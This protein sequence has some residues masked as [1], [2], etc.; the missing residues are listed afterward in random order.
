MTVITELGRDIAY[1]GTSWV[2][3]LIPGEA[4]PIFEDKGETMSLQAMGLIG[5]VS[6]VVLIVV[7][8]TLIN[9]FAH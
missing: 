8:I 4:A 3:P 9:K 6:A 2:A 5:L 7:A 1:P